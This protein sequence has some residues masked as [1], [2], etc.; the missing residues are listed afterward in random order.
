[1]QPFQL[2]VPTSWDQAAKSLGPAWEGPRARGAGVDL[3]DLIKEGVTA[4]TALVNLRSVKREIQPVSLS[5]DGKTLMIDALATLSQ[6]AA[7]ELILRHATVLSEAASDAATP[8][9]RNIA[10]VAG[11]LCQSPRCWYYRDKDTVCTRKGGE[12]CPALTGENK[13]HAIFG[14]GACPVVHPSNLA[15]AMVAVGAVFSITGAK[16]SREVAAADFFTRPATGPIRENT[17]APDELIT[18]VKVPVNAS[19]RATSMELREK[20]SFDWAT[21]AVAGSCEMDGK[22]AGKSPRIVLAS[23][24][25]TPWVCTKAQEFIAGKILDEATAAKAGELAVEGAKPMSQ[26]GYK[27]RQASV[28]VKRAL[29]RLAGDWERRR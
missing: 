13:Y 9:I 3:F 16:A 27:V 12:G 10:T 26:N 29:L 28:L 6:I 18:A 5:A 23:V 15:P 4:P 20:Q 8:N 2:I 17:L 11:N 14:G 21:V 19:R 22:R 1:M 24:A 7:H 25:P